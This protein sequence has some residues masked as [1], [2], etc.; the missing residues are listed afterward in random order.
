MHG[1]QVKEVTEAAFN[2]LTGTRCIVGCRKKP[3]AIDVETSLM[4]TMVS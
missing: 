4:E 1:D 2:N 3:P